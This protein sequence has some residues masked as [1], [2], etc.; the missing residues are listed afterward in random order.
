MGYSLVVPGSKEWRCAADV[1][2]P[3]GAVVE[4]LKTVEVEA[5]AAAPVA[6]P[7]EVGS[8]WV[9]HGGRQNV[10]EIM[11]HLP[12][13]LYPLLYQPGTLARQFG[14]RAREDPDFQGSS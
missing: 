4:L 14:P 12:T 5:V 10:P 3:F 13:V 6:G 11:F 7:Q 1:W 9:D 8:P 2:G